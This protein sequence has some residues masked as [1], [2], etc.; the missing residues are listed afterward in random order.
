MKIKLVKTIDTNKIILHCNEHDI[1]LSFLQAATE[2]PECAVYE[3]NYKFIELFKKCMSIKIGPTLEDIV[4][5][6]HN[7]DWERIQHEQLVLY[8]KITEKF[9]RDKNDSV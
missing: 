5:G 3:I 6:H 1:D 4:E 2:H 8:D 7:N 9:D